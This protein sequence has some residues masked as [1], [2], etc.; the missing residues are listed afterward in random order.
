[1]GDSGLRTQRHHEGFIGEEAASKILVVKDTVTVFVP[2]EGL[3]LAAR[4][5]SF[6][7]RCLAR[8]TNRAGVIMSA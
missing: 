6:R 1:V 4:W 3:C 2:V 5:L 8:R 7:R